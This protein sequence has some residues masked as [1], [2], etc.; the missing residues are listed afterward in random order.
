MIRKFWIFRKPLVFSICSF[1]HMD[2]SSEKIAESNSR[3][4]LQDF[5]SKSESQNKKLI[6]SKESRRKCS[7]GHLDCGSQLHQMSSTRIEKKDHFKIR[8]SSKVF[9]STRRKQ[10]WELYPVFLVHSQNLVKTWKLFHSNY[11]FLK[12]FDWR[13]WKL[14]WQPCQFCLMLRKCFTYCAEPTKKLSFSP[15][16]TTFHHCSTGHIKAVWASCQTFF[17][18]S[19]KQVTFVKVF[20]KLFSSKSFCGRVKVFFDRLAETTFA[21][22]YIRILLKVRKW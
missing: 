15:K 18:Q 21:K 11:V 17:A 13:W 10:I 22:S 9:P 5:C 19:R 6:F 12:K 16:N 1:V 3:K 8:F 2:V 7:S 20:R 14:N 4:V